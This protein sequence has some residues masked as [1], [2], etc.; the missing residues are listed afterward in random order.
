MKYY[1]RI[2][3]AKAIRQF[4]LQPTFEGKMERDSEKYEK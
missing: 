3:E 2:N 4:S 1:M